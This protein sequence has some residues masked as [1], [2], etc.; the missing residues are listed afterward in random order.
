MR[1]CGARSVILYHR[2]TA[3]TT[4]CYADV[5][6][7]KTRFV[8]AK[9]AL[10]CAQKF[11]AECRCIAPLRQEQNNHSYHTDIFG[12]RQRGQRGRT[13]RRGVVRPGLLYFRLTPNFSKGAT[14]KCNPSSH[15][16]LKPNLPIYMDRPVVKT[17]ACLV[18]H[19]WGRKIDG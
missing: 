14:N 12:R 15:E 19:A 16:G 2:W 17:R 8:C 18:T 5:S 6:G 10:D 3:A 13:A 1:T 11:G 7:M 9:H 4:A